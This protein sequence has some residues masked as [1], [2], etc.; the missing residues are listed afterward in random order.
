MKDLKEIKSLQV[1]ELSGTK[2]TDVGLKELKELKG[3]ESLGVRETM[4][5]D[6][7][8]A[9]LK[10]NFRL[11]ESPTKIFR[12]LYAVRNPRSTRA[13]TASPDGTPVI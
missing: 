11:V 5:T 7:G 12:S 8:V 3:L 10:T 9:E 2:I 1:L 13:G 6:A 4:V